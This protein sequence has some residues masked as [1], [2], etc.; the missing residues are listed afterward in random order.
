M[1]ILK[2]F[3]RISESYKIHLNNK[4]NGYLQL[5]LILKFMKYQLFSIYLLHPKNSNEQYYV[6]TH[7]D[8]M[9]K[10]LTYRFHLVPGKSIEQFQFP[11]NQQQSR[12]KI[13]N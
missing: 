10:V 13:W 2:Y 11:N 9:V 12:Q 1:N 8:K 5:S 6:T 3:Y 4:K 7:D